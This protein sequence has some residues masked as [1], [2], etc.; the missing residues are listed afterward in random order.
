VAPIAGGRAVAQRTLEFLRVFEPD[1]MH[2]H[3]PFSPGAN[4]A[5]LVGTFIPAVGTF[6]SARAGRNG[7]YETLRPGIRPLMNKLTVK[8][9]VS[10][11]AAR[12]VTLTFGEE[13]EILPNGVEVGMFAAGPA[14]TAPHPAVVFVGRHEPRKGL[15]VLLDAF[16]GL[17]RA[18]DLWVIGDGPQ[19]VALR[20]R[21]LPGVHWL[22]TVSDAGK[23]AHLR[24]ATIAC[25]PA[26]DGESFGV[27]LL[28]GMAAGAAVIASD[29][30]GYRTVARQGE[31][32]ILV[33]PGD[34]DALRE[35]LRMLLD[36]AERRAR[37]VAAGRRRA[38]EFSMSRLAERF[39]EVYERALA[40]PRANA[41]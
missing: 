21:G 6:H 25:F 12:Q 36:D 18:A 9:A 39:V 17:G 16:D 34:P 20:A 33:P 37:L 1:V 15:G 27:V 31:E 22:G 3:E 30:D 2:L 13:C 5:A 38:A 7:W 8:T 35:A 23:A 41:T 26:L 19:S 29:I 11:D 14:T 32:A 4:H 40:I 10:A 24:G 28:E